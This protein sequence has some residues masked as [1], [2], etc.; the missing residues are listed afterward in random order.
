MTPQKVYRWGV[1]MTSIESMLF[2]KY[3][4]SPDVPSPNTLSHNERVQLLQNFL[5][6]PLSTESKE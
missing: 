4:D 2:D 6:N 5:N 1:S 3:L